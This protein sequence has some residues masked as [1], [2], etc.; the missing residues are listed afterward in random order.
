MVAGPVTQ[1]AERLDDHINWQLLE[2]A[3]VDVIDPEGPRHRKDGVF[4]ALLGRIAINRDCT[5][6]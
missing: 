3:G 4:L 5:H 6:A 2:Q 1:P